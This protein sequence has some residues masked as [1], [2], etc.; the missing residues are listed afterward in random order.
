MAQ[1]DTSVVLPP[2][3]IHNM[4]LAINAWLAA[5]ALQHEH[6]L[7]PYQLAEIQE[8][9]LAVEDDGIAYWQQALHS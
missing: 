2:H 9:Q 3:S 8:Y 5:V 1:H 7:M 6:Q 4:A